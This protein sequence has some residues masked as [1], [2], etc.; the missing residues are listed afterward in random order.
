MHLNQ[1]VVRMRPLQPHEAGHSSS[2][3]QLI[4]EKGAIV[5]GDTGMLLMTLWLSPH[6]LNRQ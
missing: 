1:V 4:P 6:S 3:L 5:V 2:S